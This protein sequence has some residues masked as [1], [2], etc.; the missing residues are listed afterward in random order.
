MTW[1]STGLDAST[2][3]PGSMREVMVGTRSV[4]VVHIGTGIFAL[5]ATC[6]HIGG[7]LTDGTLSGPQLTCPEHAARFDVRTGAVLSDP[8]GVE[9]PE[10]GVDPVASYPTRLAAGIV[11]VELP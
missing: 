6:P 5:E 2:L 9:P 8:F 11:E 10:G 3:A 1:Q 4:L 7:L